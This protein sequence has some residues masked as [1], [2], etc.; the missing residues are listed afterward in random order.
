MEE[1]TKEEESNSSGEMCGVAPY[2]KIH[3]YS[4]RGERVTGQ[5]AG[6]DKRVERNR[7]QSR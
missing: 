5:G 1:L 2:M 6:R 3:M 7:E 4:M